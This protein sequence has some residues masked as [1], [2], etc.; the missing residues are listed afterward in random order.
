LDQFRV[1][2]VITEPSAVAPDARINPCLN[3]VAAHRF[4]VTLALTD[5]Y[6]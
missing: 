6:H 1:S 4:S 5:G 2:E 3:R